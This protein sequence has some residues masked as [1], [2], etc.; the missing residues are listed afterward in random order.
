[1]RAGPLIKSLGIIFVSCSIAYSSNQDNQSLFDSEKVFGCFSFNS[2]LC[3]S[4][5]GTIECLRAYEDSCRLLSRILNARTFSMLETCHYK[6][7]AGACSGDDAIVFTFNFGETEIN[8][9][10]S[11]V[12]SIIARNNAFSSI[13][14]ERLLNE[15]NDLLLG[16]F[17]APGEGQFKIQ[18]SENDNKAGEAIGHL[19]SWFHPLLAWKIDSETIKLLLNCHDVRKGDGV[20]N[21]ITSNQFVLFPQLREKNK[22]I[23]GLRKDI[24]Q[25][26]QQ[27][28]RMESE[29]KL[30]TIP[31]YTGPT[32][33]IEDY[34]KKK[35]EDRQATATPS[36]R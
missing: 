36:S 29:Q 13:D 24:Q 16:L 11:R 22:I 20:D 35:Q 4:S 26:L 34:L 30:P 32:M 28:S 31:T 7:C 33:T 1:M 18:L 3:E 25:Q 10:Y 19:D 21:V 9:I 17:K 5:C 12:V 23:P 15:I 14:Q 27:N 2:E 8:I 6:F